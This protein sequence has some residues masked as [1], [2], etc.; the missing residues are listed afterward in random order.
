M[1]I[2]LKIYAREKNM[3]EIREMLEDLKKIIG[4]WNVTSQFMVT[5][6]IK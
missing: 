6:W 3:E 2:E 4:Q 5:G 1:N